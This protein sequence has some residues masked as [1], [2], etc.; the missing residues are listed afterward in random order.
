M[1]MGFSNAFVGDFNAY[2]FSLMGMLIVFV[3]LVLIYLYIEFLPHFLD[4]LSKR[5]EKIRQRS[6]IR[7]KK[8]TA[9]P[10]HFSVVNINQEDTDEIMLAIAA[11]LH[12]EHGFLGDNQQYTWKQDV[13][14]NNWGMSGKINSL[15]SRSSKTSW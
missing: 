13:A 10:K 6:R 15:S 5:R 7:F 2:M 3:G 8:E 12:L 1:N 4:F 11:A 9:S 14:G